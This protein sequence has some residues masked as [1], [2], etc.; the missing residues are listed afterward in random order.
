MPRATRRAGIKRRLCILKYAYEN[1]SAEEFSKD[2]L[3]T[4]SKTHDDP[5]YEAIFAAHNPSANELE[6]REGYNPHKP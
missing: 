4:G 3:G 6:R 1:S 2:S 5:E